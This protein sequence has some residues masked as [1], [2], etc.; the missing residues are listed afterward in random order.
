MFSWFL[1]FFMNQKQDGPKIAKLFFVF[2]R[3]TS[4]GF[5]TCPTYLF[6]Q[7]CYSWRSKL[8]SGFYV[9]V[10]TFFNYLFLEHKCK[11]LLKPVL[12]LTIAFNWPIENSVKRENEMCGR[13]LF[14]L[15]Y[16]TRQHILAL[17][18]RLFLPKT[19]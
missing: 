16:M 15:N 11:D 8:P 13:C 9:S 4:C 10:F 18:T 3:R 1:I 14:N 19:L 2:I 12:C 7:F 17:C 6:V 5:K